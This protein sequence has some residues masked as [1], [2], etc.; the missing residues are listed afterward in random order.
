AQRTA[1]GHSSEGH[2]PVIGAIVRA[3]DEIRT[4]S[5]RLADA[6][7]PGTRS[8]LEDRLEAATARLDELQSE[9]ALRL[10]EIAALD[11]L[12]SDK[13]GRDADRARRPR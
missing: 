5:Q 12:L 8:R 4:I 7:D 3:G 1:S 10:S 9:L 11:R 2:T 13:S 6:P